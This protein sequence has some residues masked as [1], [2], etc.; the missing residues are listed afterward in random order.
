M[1][2]LFYHF[3]PLCHLPLI[4]DTGYLKLT[5]SNLSMYRPHA[6]PDV[7]WLTDRDT[8]PNAH[9]L[10][11]DNGAQDDADSPYDKTRI[12]FTV[13]LPSPAVKPWETWI[14]GRNIDPQWRETLTRG[15]N[16]RRWWVIERP[17]VRTEW[18]AVHDAHTGAQLLGP[19][20]SPL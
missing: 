20:G 16:P 8:A 13:A 17:V 7:V 2:K 15:R 3:S 11:L 4:L 18:V 9:A 19:G 12:R 10:G 14:K 1:P 5:E 6:G